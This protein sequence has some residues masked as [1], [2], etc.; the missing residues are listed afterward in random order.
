MTPP[1]ATPLGFAES[2]VE[3]LALQHFANLGY[4][5]IHGPN[6]GPHRSRRPQAR[7]PMVAS[8]LWVM[9]G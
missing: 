3:E 1:L 8:A 7:L 4:A 6:M 9:A 5:V 2:D